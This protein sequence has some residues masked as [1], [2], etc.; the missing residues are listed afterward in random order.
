MAGDAKGGGGGD[1]NEARK[2]FKGL[3][4][5]AAGDI[6]K[7]VYGKT[8]NNIVFSFFVCVL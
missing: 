5:A 4:Y 8:K 7:K 2:K 6:Y 3:E 1:I